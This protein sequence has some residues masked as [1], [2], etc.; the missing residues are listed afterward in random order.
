MGL[1]FLTSWFAQSLAG[2]AAFNE[3]RLQRMQ[4]P[5]GWAATW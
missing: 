2:W 1:I 4:D 3:T 5:L